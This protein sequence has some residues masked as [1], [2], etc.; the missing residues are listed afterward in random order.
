MM[1]IHTRFIQ[2]LDVLFLRG[3]RLFGAA[4]SYGESLLPPWPS[5]AAGALRS[6][7]FAQNGQVLDDPADFCLTAFHLAR[8][9]GAGAEAVYAVPADLS[10]VDAGDGQ[11]QI[12]RLQPAKLAPGLASSSPLTSIPMLAQDQRSKPAS[13]HWLSSAAWQGYL[14]GQT[15]QATELL[16]TRK[17]WQLEH[18]VGVG[19]EPQTRAAADGKLFSM[20]AIAF[21]GGAGFVTVSTGRVAPPERGTLRLG[22]DGR[23]AALTMADVQLPQ[24]DHAAIVRAGRARIVLTSPGL[25]PQGWRLPG[26]DASGLLQLPGLRARVVAAAV[27]RAAVVSGWDMVR[28]QPKDAQRVAPTGSVYW[29]Q[30]LQADTATLDKLAARGLWPQSGEDTARRIEGFNRFAFAAY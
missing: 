2:P 10:V 24:G 30:A 20:Q 27:P 28:R 9:S 5:V 11:L 3:N 26:M 22:G 8:D 12:R 6:L 14:A 16:P 29:L 21:R 19:L 4:G 17:L 25:F 15:P 23:G 13:G 18:R 1:A 7:L